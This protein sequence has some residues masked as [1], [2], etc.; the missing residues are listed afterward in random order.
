VGIRC[1]DG[2]LQSRDAAMCELLA[3][4]HPLHLTHGASATEQ[5]WGQW[6]DDAGHGSLSTRRR[7]RFLM[8][9]QTLIRRFRTSRCARSKR[10]PAAR[11][12][13][14]GRVFA[15]AWR[16]STEAESAGSIRPC[17]RMHC[18]LVGRRSGGRIGSGLQGWRPARGA[19]AV[20][21]GEPWEGSPGSLDEVLAER[22]DRVCVIGLAR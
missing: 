19:D 21:C 2:H 22:A 10:R 11:Y 6:G 3:G 5:G 8:C 16:L 12:S 4:A 20:S 14:G 1:S 7:R 15:G 17:V 18:W 13:L 9:G